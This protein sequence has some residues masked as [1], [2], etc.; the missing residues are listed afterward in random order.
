[1]AAVKFYDAVDVV[2]AVATGRFLGHLSF[3]NALRMA[4][5]AILVNRAAAAKIAKMVSSR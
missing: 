1:M 4:K 3:F 5:L 2:V